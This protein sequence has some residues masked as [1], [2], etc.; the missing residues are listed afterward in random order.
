MY[1][2]EQLFDPHFWKT[3][4]TDDYKFSVPKH[5]ESM[6]PWAPAIH[7]Q[8]HNGEDDDFVLILQTTMDTVHPLI[9][10]KEQISDSLIETW[11]KLLKN[12]KLLQHEW[13]TDEHLPYFFAEYE[14]LLEEF[15]ITTWYYMW[16]VGRK[17][18]MFSMIF[19]SGAPE[20]NDD[21]ELLTQVL[22]GLFKLKINLKTEE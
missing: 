13:V 18:I 4:E 9:Q 12:F 3:Y 7:Y 15:E 6:E 16:I 22:L 17:S 8:I 21:F 11:P 5:W 2:K 1:T 20:E 10:N 14:S 19:N